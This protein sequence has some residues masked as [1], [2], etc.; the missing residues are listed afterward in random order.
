MLQL[1]KKKVDAVLLR[2]Q[3]DESRSRLFIFRLEVAAQ[4]LQHRLVEVVALRQKCSCALKQRFLESTTLFFLLVLQCFTLDF[5]DLHVVELL[6]H[7]F[8]VI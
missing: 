4:V 3:L 6:L 5:D 8:F 2:P 7:F 1:R